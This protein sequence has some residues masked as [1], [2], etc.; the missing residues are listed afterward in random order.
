VC[1]IAEAENK[2][3][4][5]KLKVVVIGDAA[6][7]KTSLIRNF[8]EGLSAL[9]TSPH[10]TMGMDIFTVPLHLSKKNDTQL[11]LWD[12][13]GSQR[14]EAIRPTFYRGAQGFIAVLDITRYETFEHLDTWISELEQIAGKQLP[15]NILANKVD[16]EEFRAVKF[17]EI[18]DFAKA[19]GLSVYRT[20][21]V[22]GENV[23]ESFM[24]LARKIHKG[25]VERAGLAEAD[26]EQ[27]EEPEEAAK[28][29]A[30]KKAARKEKAPAKKKAA[31][32]PKVPAK[33]KT[34]ASKESQSQKSP[35]VLK[36]KS[37]KK[38][39]EE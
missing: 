6:V 1:P 35:L 7:G 26:E 21:A 32:K 31:A 8:T 16:L 5:F 15:G 39:D 11:N 2:N 3:F 27:P 12:I 18:E 25:V 34:A 4:D 33:K 30:K 29:P 13:G 14:F 36:P 23:N 9:Q 38:D 20:S 19:R 37:K 24:W 10:A 17:K 22:T 28:S